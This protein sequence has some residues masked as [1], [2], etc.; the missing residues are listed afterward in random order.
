M[1]VYGF[2]IGE[3]GTVTADRDLLGGKGAALVEMSSTG[4]IPV[5]PGV[6]VPTT[7]CREYTSDPLLA[8]ELVTDA[9]HSVAEVLA[10]IEHKVGYLPL[11]SVRSGAP[12]SMPG[13]MDTILNV[14]LTPSTMPRW[15][16]RLGER[17]AKDSYRRLLQMYGSVVLRIPSELFEKKLAET[18]KYYYGGDQLP[19]TDADLTT[20]HLDKLIIRYL[21][22]YQAKGKVVPNTVSEQIRGCMLAVVKSWYNVRAQKYRKMHGIP[23][24]LGTAITVQMM[25][26]GNAGNSSCSGVLFSRDPFTGEK[27]VVGE[28]LPNAQGEDVVAGVRTPISFSDMA[29]WSAPLHNELEETAIFLEEH[30]KDMQDIEFTVQEGDLYILQTRNAKRTVQASFQVAYDLLNEDVISLEEARARIPFGTLVAL[31]GGSVPKSFKE[32]PTYV[33]LPGATGCVSGVVVLNNEQACKL[34]TPDMPVLLVR[35]ET[36]PEDLPG[37][38]ASAGFLTRTGGSTC[39]AAVVARGLNKAAVVG[40]SDLP[41]DLETLKGKFITIDGG[42][43]RVWLD[44][45]VPMESPE[46]PESAIGLISL[47]YRGDPSKVLEIQDSGDGIR[48]PIIDGAK[49]MV[50]ADKVDLLDA[51]QVLTLADN[52]KVS[53]VFVLFDSW[54]SVELSDIDRIL[55]TDELFPQVSVEAPE[56]PVLC[57][58]LGE[59]PKVTVCGREAISGDLIGRRESIILEVFR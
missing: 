6:V 13:M 42:T 38:A 43:G 15:I 7:L 32:P 39:H 55:L 9:F 21:D 30:Y 37:M 54:V 2:G 45:E 33:G 48:A 36:S 8:E 20:K 18:K 23:D 34:A 56:N 58:L 50:C 40:C 51:A 31:F 17:V 53:E 14:G 26:F 19:V 27:G 29:E 41:K 12:V 1:Q 35:N 44:I 3:A 47:L 28:F 49:V 52:P 11:F 46:I 25:V 4:S 59:H 22:L 57:G 16:D 10:V 24:S 5:P